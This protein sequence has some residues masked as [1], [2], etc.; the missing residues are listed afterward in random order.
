MAGCSHDEEADVMRSTIMEVA[1]DLFDTTDDVG[2]D[3]IAASA[4]ITAP[5]LRL[6]FTSPAAIERELRAQDR[7]RF[8]ELR[9][10]APLLAAG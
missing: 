8:G 6:Y 3:E 2:L 10:T 7:H 9:E 1:A 4:G 5:H